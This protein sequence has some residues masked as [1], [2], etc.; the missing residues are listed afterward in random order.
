MLNR[1]FLKAKTCFYFFNAVCVYVCLCVLFPF[2][3]FQLHIKHP[4][5]LR[6]IFIPSDSELLHKLMGTV[7]SFKDKHHEAEVKQC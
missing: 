6:C 5:H 3:T 4:L 7:L 1:V 2:Y